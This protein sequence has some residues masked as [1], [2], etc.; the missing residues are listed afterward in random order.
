MSNVV[1]FTGST[2][3][4]YSPERVLDQLKECNLEGFALV[5]YTKDGEEFFCTTYADIQKVNWLLDRYKKALLES[6]DE[7]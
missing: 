3:P 4:D 5:G 2:T 1:D 7:L 6:V